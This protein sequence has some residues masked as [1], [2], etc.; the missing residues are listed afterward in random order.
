ML[1]LIRPPVLPSS[2]D[3]TKRVR[4]STHAPNH[5]AKER[6]AS[7]IRLQN[8]LERPD[9]R[10][11]FLAPCAKSDQQDNQRD[12]GTAAARRTR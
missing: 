12:R 3:L 6:C 4:A 10:T 5:E 11:V 8:C 1:P 7:V 9:A 2:T